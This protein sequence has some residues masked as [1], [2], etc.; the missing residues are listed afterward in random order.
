MNEKDKNADEILQKRIDAARIVP[1]IAGRDIG[2]SA[3]ILAN[4]Q[5]HPLEIPK[6]RFYFVE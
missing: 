6:E 3:L 4:G 1:D 2:S 5:V